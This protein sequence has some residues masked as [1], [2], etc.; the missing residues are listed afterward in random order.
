M[1]AVT[2]C[3]NT[4]KRHKARAYVTHVVYR[5]ITYY[6]SAYVTN[7]TITKLSLWSIAELY[8]KLKSKFGIYEFFSL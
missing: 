7:T 6:L 1:A 3:E 5:V 4:L 2:S 8:L